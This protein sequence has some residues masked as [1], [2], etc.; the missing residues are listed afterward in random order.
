MVVVSDN[1]AKYVST[2]PTPV[3]TEMEMI[4]PNNEI[5]M[6][7][8]AVLICRQNSHPFQ[9]RTLMLDEPVKIGRSVARARA[10]ANNAIFDCKVLSRNHALLWYDNGKFFL[11][12]TVSS[13]G[14]FVNNHKL[15]SDTDHH[16]VSSGDIVQ[17]GVDV[18]E[19]NRKVTH[20]CII[21]TLK[22]YLPDGKEAKA[23]PSIEENNKH[24]MVPLDELYKL[25]QIIQDASD[26]EQCLQ[27][28][29]AKLQSMLQTA[30]TATSSCWAAYV[31]EERL[32]SRIAT[33]ETQLSQANKNWTEDR[34]KQELNK[35]Q[36]DNV[37]YQVAAIE[38]LEKLHNEKLDAV[39]YVSEMEIKENILQQETNLAKIQV[40]DLHKE[41]DELLRKFMEE[42]K[43]T[44]ELR[45]EFEP[46]IKDLQKQLYDK[47]EE[48]STLKLKFYNKDITTSNNMLEFDIHS[49]INPLNEM[50]K[51]K[52]EIDNEKQKDTDNDNSNDQQN[53]FN[54]TVGSGMDDENDEYSNH[55]ETESNG[56]IYLDDSETTQFSKNQEIQIELS[57]AENEKS[58]KG[59]KFDVPEDDHNK[60]SDETEENEK[61]NEEEPIEEKENELVDHID[62]KTLKYHFQS[63]Q[64]ELKKKIEVLEQL[65]KSHQEKNEEVSALYEEEKT[66][67]SKFEA[68]NK[69]LKDELSVCR[70][71]LERSR[72]ENY[73]LKNEVNFLLASK[74]IGAGDSLTEPS[75]EKEKITLV[76]QSSS[77]KV[78]SY[79]ELVAVE[80][81]LVL[82]KE[83]FSQV[84]SEKVKLLQDIK[85]L[86]KEYISVKN[87]SHNMTFL[88]VAPL[89]LIVLYLLMSNMFS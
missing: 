64:N 27:K 15:T 31:G 75:V 74:E 45:K 52:E 6:T 58:E 60:C 87:H 9:D 21:A 46:K 14:T 63:T 53:D 89:V 41:I 56:T 72:R 36:D 1:W 30:K 13:N 24:G 7:A 39:A 25:N 26:R 12:D 38:A 77:E 37:A 20:G 49:Y 57:V 28:K 43:K 35:I 83:R 62:S 71:N 29:L 23:S 61:Q 78:I 69:E 44:E 80:E 48:L 11:Q 47:Q 17:F 16:E 88:Y 86:E 50:K 8:K 32:L 4:I 76:E 66:L 65:C 33:L 18:V 3:M 68:D 54:L 84:N 79:E 10:K 51:I 67:L 55:S 42:Q 70:E 19:N 34:C 22:L 2:F 73:D 59:V 85:G 82:L 81:E 40:E 5:K